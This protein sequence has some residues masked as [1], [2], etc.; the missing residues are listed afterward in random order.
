MARNCPYWKARSCVPPG[1]DKYPCNWSGDDF[2]ACSVYQA[3]PPPPHEQE[4][5]TVF[6]EA[7]VF[8]NGASDAQLGAQILQAMQPGCFFWPTPPRFFVH[9][10][11]GWP[12]QSEVGLEKRCTAFLVDGGVHPSQFLFREGNRLR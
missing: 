8:V 6:R 2:W 10:A 5:A 7:H 12:W 4:R 9:D 1:G 3:F 11:R